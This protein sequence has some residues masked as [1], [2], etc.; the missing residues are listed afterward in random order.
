[1]PDDLP[2]TDERPQKHR[3]G[4]WVV[5]VIGLIGLGIGIT[6]WRGSFKDVFATKIGQ[7]KT[8][9]QVEAERIAG[10][11]SKDTDTDG[12][13]DYEESYV[14]RTSP[15]LSDSDSDGLD[16]RAELQ[17]GEDPNCPKGK[18]CAAA[19]GAISGEA[20]DAGAEG[21]AGA[22]TA[23]DEEAIIEAFLNPT[24]D[25]IRD[26]LLRS[27][28]KAEEL[29]GIDDATLLQLYRESLAEAQA[30]IE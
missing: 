13:N 26:L 25:E 4:A 15:Y 18:E 8:P 28:V 9:D 23:G 20:K 29:E 7:F 5:L 16:D 2:I 3:A 12:L 27:G 22:E 19:L 1:M 30:K 24:P 10:M 6:Q 14:Y 21:E 17:A 11:K